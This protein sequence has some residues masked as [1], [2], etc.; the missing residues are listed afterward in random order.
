[1]PGGRFHWF[2][3]ASGQQNEAP[4]RHG[5]TGMQVFAVP[6]SLTSDPALPVG[7]LV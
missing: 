3:L 7:V 5:E 4:R 2:V 1:M 6:L